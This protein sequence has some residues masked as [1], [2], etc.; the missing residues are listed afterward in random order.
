[1]P[2]AI[3]VPNAFKSLTEVLTFIPSVIVRQELLLELNLL[4]SLHPRVVGDIPPCCRSRA[5]G[6]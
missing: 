5:Y 3:A 1:M 2:L 4:T 6:Q